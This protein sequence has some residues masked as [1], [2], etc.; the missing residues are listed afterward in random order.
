MSRHPRLPRPPDEVSECDCGQPIEA[1]ASRPD[2]RAT[3]IDTP[4]NRALP[5]KSPFRPHP[6]S[7]SQSKLAVSAEQLPAEGQAN[8]S[9]LSQNADDPRVPSIPRVPDHQMLRPIGRG[10]YGEVW[11]ARNVMGTFRAVKVVYRK[12]FESDRPFEREFIGLRKFEPV[13]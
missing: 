8:L 5:E 2:P 7:P 12:T 13:S 6:S 9:G 11:L 10:S 3:P 4:E 1:L